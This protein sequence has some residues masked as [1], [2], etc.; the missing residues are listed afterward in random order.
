[1]KMEPREYYQ[2]LLAAGEITADTGQETAV[3]AL[4]HLLAKL[5]RLTK[6]PFWPWTRPDERRGLYIHGPVGRGKTM[7]MDM[8]YESVTG[9]AKRRVHF[10]EF[11]LDV[12]RRLHDQ[13]YRENTDAIKNVAADIAHQAHLLCFDEFQVHNIAD[14]MILSRF[15]RE[16]FRFGVVVVAT[17]NFAPDDLYSEGLQRALFLPFID[18]LKKRLMV[19]DVGDGTDYRLARLKG[20]PVYLTPADARAHE[21]LLAL[22][23]RLTDAEEGPPEDIAV[24]GRGLHVPKA[25]K[26]VAWFHFDDLCRMPLGAADYLALTAHYHTLIVEGVPALGD[27]LRNE[28]LRFVHLVDVLYDKRIKLAL[29]AELPLEKLFTA[30]GELAQR[31]SRTLS[32]LQEMQSEE[33]V[34]APHAVMANA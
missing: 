23:K 18:L 6:K 12:H 10:H 29:S 15:F 3:S 27:E 11:M 7:L 22:F 4:A 32:R 13:L 16:L 19:I 24:A 25:A 9:V 34:Q 21:Q 30:S 17:S 14:A 2:A 28:S 33:Y 1:M 5:P 31:A 26:G 8:L 20:L